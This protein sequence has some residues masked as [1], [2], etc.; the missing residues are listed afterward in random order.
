LVPNTR[1]LLFTTSILLSPCTTLSVFII[2]PKNILPHRRNWPLHRRKRTLK[3]TLLEPPT[4]IPTSISTLPSSKRRRR[5]RI[6]NLQSC[7]SIRPPFRAPRLFSR[8]RIPRE[9]FEVLQAFAVL[10]VVGGDVG[11]VFGVPG[12]GFVAEGAGECA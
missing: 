4:S 6:K 3:T 8:V 5:R 9:L 11:F 12:V 10:V 7:L 2:I 1:N